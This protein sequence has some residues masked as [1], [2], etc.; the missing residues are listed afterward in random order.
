MEAGAQ[1]VSEMGAP[2]FEPEISDSVHYGCK[3]AHSSHIQQLEVAVGS[4][5]VPFEMPLGVVG[6]HNDFIAHL[7]TI[8]QQS[9][10][11][12]GFHAHMDVGS[13]AHS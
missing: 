2:F 3:P 8:V 5:V 11:L 10:S 1:A 4:P 9:E 6:G 12:H 13:V 7:H